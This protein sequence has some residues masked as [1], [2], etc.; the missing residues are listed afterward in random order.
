MKEVYDKIATSFDKLA[1]CYRELSN[2]D[3]T[4][5]NEINSDK[6][7]NQSEVVTIEKIRAVLSEKSKIGKTKEVKALLSK[8]GAKKLSQVKEEDFTALML[9]SQKL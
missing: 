9:E 3:I 4:G 1:K 7:V 5:D 6:T 2:W 8:F